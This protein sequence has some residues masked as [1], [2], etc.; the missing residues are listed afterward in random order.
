MKKGVKK[1]MMEK[2]LE[3]AEAFAKKFPEVIAGYL[4]YLKNHENEKK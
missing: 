2:D 3:K 1:N 4:I